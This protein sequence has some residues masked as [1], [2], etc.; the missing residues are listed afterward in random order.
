MD[1]TLV[2]KDLP[3][4]DSKMLSE[5]RH[6]QLAVLSGIVKDTRTLTIILQSMVKDRET[7]DRASQIFAYTK[8]QT[9]IE[10]R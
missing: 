10:T 5:Y 1:Q 4:T 8:T 6:F 9:I 2:G 7:R 3:R